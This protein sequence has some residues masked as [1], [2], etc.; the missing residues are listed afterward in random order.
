MGSDASRVNVSLIV[1]GKVTWRCPSTTIWPRMSSQQFV[2]TLQQVGYP[3]ADSLNASTFDWMFEDEAVLPFLSWFCNTVGPQNVLSPEEKQ[4]WVF[5]F[6]QTLLCRAIL[7]FGIY[8]DTFRHSQKCLASQYITLS[9]NLNQ[10]QIIYILPN[11]TL[12]NNLVN[13]H[14]IT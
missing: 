8:T 3:K 12:S 6:V 13:Q 2:R 11:I 1:Q 10:H 4:A 9:N 5:T 7:G 14:Q